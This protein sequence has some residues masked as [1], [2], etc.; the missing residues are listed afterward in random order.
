MVLGLMGEPSAVK[1]LLPMLV[2]DPSPAIRLQA[3]ESLWRLGNEQG[4]KALVVSTVTNYSDDRMIA[5]LALAGPRNPRALGH[6][7]GHLTSQYDEVSLAAA[8]AAGM[9]GSEEGY[10]VALKGAK[11]TDPRQ[12]MLAA[13]AM[14][15]IGR[16]DSQPPLSL[17]LKDPDQDVRIAAATA[18][19]QLKQ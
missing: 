9:L 10:G 4:M 6:I 3:A 17:L 12:R 19:L 5:V 1:I 15:A 8:R 14:G 11:S 7:G 16:P 18:I 2:A 13:L